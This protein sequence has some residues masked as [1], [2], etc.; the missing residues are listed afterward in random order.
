L[1]RL[2]ASCTFFVSRWLDKDQVRVSEVRPNEFRVKC[3]K[4][5][6]DQEIKGAIVKYLLSKQK[7][8]EPMSARDPLPFDE[9]HDVP[10][11]DD[12]NG[13]LSIR[14]DVLARDD[15]EYIETDEEDGPDLDEEDDD[16]EADEIFGFGEGE[17]EGMD[18]DEEDLEQD[19]VEEEEEGP[20]EEDVRDAEDL[21]GLDD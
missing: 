20:T 10:Y 13:N 11:D 1:G 7:R 3:G 9:M 4:I 17:D 6:S 19:Y 18:D 12:G 5:L 2:V 15:D 14:G 8:I 16:E 21:E